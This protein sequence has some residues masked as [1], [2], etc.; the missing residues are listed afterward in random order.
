MKTNAT[1]NESGLLSS[2]GIPESSC[3]SF[4]SWKE[5]PSQTV[6]RNLTAWFTA[7]LFLLI[8][9]PQSWG[10]TLEESVTPGQP[11]VVDLIPQA[12]KV[13][14]GSGAMMLK[15]STP[16]P[17]ANPDVPADL[18]C[19]DLRVVFILDESNS[20]NTLGAVDRKSV[21]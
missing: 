5:S 19:S 7:M 17:L 21:V 13:S 14:F 1:R 16:T 20:I 15:S 8:M 6:S 3:W 9:T 2:E 18:V 4:L 11:Q 12:S 10:Q